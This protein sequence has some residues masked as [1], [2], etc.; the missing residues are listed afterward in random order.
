[1]PNNQLLGITKKSGDLSLVAEISMFDAADVAP[2]AEATPTIPPPP[3]PTTEEVQAPE[4][5]TSSSESAEAEVPASEPDSGDDSSAAT[6]EEVAADGEQE[7][8]PVIPTSTEPAATATDEAVESADSAEEDAT[9]NVEETVTEAEAV[10]ETE[11]EATEEVAEVLPVDNSESEQGGSDNTEEKTQTETDEIKNEDQTQS[12]ASEADTAAQEAIVEERPTLAHILTPSLVSQEIGHLVRPANPILI[13]DTT[14]IFNTGVY[15]RPTGGE[16]A[17]MF[18]TYSSVGLELIEEA[19]VETA[20]ASE[21]VSI[22]NFDALNDAASSDAPIAG[23][24]DA[25]LMEMLVAPVPLNA[26]P[27]TTSALP[28]LVD[29]QTI[30]A[31]EPNTEK[32]ELVVINDDGHR[33]IT[34]IVEGELEAGREVLIIKPNQDGIAVINDY[35]DESNKQYDAVIIYSHGINNQI[36][37]GDYTLTNENVADS[38]IDGFSEHLSAGADII[39]ASCNAA[40]SDSGKAMIDQIAELT[41]A[42]VGASSDSTGNSETGDWDLEYQTGAL[43]TDFAEEVKANYTGTDFDNVLQTWEWTDPQGLVHQYKFILHTGSDYQS[44]AAAETDAHAFTSAESSDWYLATFTSQAEYDAYLALINGTNEGP[45]DQTNWAGAWFGA[46]SVADGTNNYY[47]GDDQS[48]EYL[49]AIANNNQ[50]WDP[51]DS[52][53]AG[54]SPSGGGEAGGNDY[55]AVILNDVHNSGGSP[56]DSPEREGLWHTV[57]LDGSH[58]DSNPNPGVFQSDAYIIE[59]ILAAEPPVI[60]P[61]PTTPNNL[62]GCLAV[63]YEG[64]GAIAIAPNI[65]ITDPDSTNFTQLALSFTAGWESTD[66]VSWS[67]GAVPAG[68]S[69]SLATAADGTPTGLTVTGSA[70]VAAYNTLAQSITFDSTTQDATEVDRDI[71]WMVLDDTIAILGGPQASTVGTSSVCV[72][73]VPEP[74]VITPP[75]YEI[76]PVLSDP[77]DPN[78][79]LVGG[80]TAVYT[81]NGDPVLLAADINFTD[82]DS[83]NLTMAT[84][85]MTGAWEATDVVAWDAAVVPA[86]VTVTLATAADGTPTG[87]VIDGEATKD[88]YVAIAQSLNYMSTSE[89]PSEEPRELTW[90]IWDDTP[91]ETNAAHE[92]YLEEGPL[93]S[94]IVVTSVCVDAVP[95]PPVITPPTFELPP[96]LSDPND[97]DSPLVGGCTAVYTENGDPVL[98]AA[99]INFT[100]IDSENLTMATIDMTGAWEAT[101]VV[102]WDT[103]VVPAGVTVTLATAADGTPTGIVIDGEATKAEYVAIAQ[104]LNYMSTSENPS[105]EPRELTWEIWD[106]TPDQDNYAHE[107]ALEEGPLP[108]NI[109]VTSVCVDAV[110]DAPVITPPTYEI[111]PV[112]SDPDDPNSPL[113]GGCTAVYTENG[114]PVLLAADINFTDIDSDNLTMATIDMTGAWEATDVV[115]WDTA[116]VPAGVTVTL[117]TAADGTPTGIVIDGEATKA[118]YVAIAQSLNYMSTSEEPS[119][120]PRELTWEIWDDTPVEDNYAHENALEE[121][122]LPSN[123]VV[124]SV[125]VDAVPDAPVIVNE[126]PP[127]LNDPDDP[128]PT[129]PNNPDC[130][131]DVI[132][133]ENGEAVLL[134]PAIDFSD[135][136]SEFLTS[137]TIDFSSPL[138]EDFSVTGV[139][140]WEPT[141]IVTWDAAVVPAGVTVTLATAADGTPTGIVI[142]GEATLAEYEALFQSISYVTESERPSEG[143]RVITVQIWDDTPVEDNYAFENALEEGPLSSNIIVINLCVDAVPDAPDV[144]LNPN[145]LPC[146]EIVTGQGHVD[147]FPQ[148]TITDIDS[149]NLTAMNL[150]FTVNNGD[151]I[152]WDDALVPE[153][154][155]VHEAFDPDGVYYVYFTGTAPVEE[156]EALLQSFQ[157]QS[158]FVEGTQSHEIGVSVTVFDDTPVEENGCYEQFGENG[159]VTSAELG[160]LTDHDTFC[161][162]VY[163]PP[164]PPSPEHPASFT[165]IP[166]PEEELFLR[167]V[168]PEEIL[169]KTD[170]SILEG[171][172]PA[173][174]FIHALVNGQDAILNAQYDENHFV[175]QPLQRTLTDGQALSASLQNSID[176]LAASGVSPEGIAEGMRNVDPAIIGE[177]DQAMRLEHAIAI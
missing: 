28:L 109:V 78:S 67:A 154:V 20:S 101:D 9:A 96:V 61:D 116:V 44:W 133:V 117:A 134:M 64:D 111:P 10:V 93:P 104:S 98:L 115:A 165:M 160:A 142:D 169:R 73:A 100:D 45:I 172:T 174:I 145:N 171:D 71:T 88:E 110:P 25:D 74:P 138:T 3:E 127:E 59:T 144:E 36:I 99:D 141:D 129:Y 27:Q 11:A 56:A 35:L 143:E 168:E 159:G 167:H 70:S 158:N 123:I 53:P 43:E 87:I 1:M 79:P 51:N 63:W 135:L 91:D 155:S 26:I 148:A 31:L 37:L 72:D 50:N 107:N 22:V 4:E 29:E 118:E 17:D 121:G 108:S 47:W 156:Y 34:E 32:V 94:N 30:A 146:T 6:T 176:G 41:G 16:W 55:G 147:M 13:G 95:E 62:E 21:A 82:I 140:G 124:T 139:Q 42:D 126:Y 113:V 163:T 83:D 132:F 137:A 7:P 2:V 119:E 102:A 166:I 112:L 77:D 12:P 68:V 8:E 54:S 24:I 57:P 122:P 65:S 177:L 86:G 75:T 114:D 18:P 106:D 40:E 49:D 60:D 15:G 120:D 175:D 80:C 5:E 38:G 162:H 66:V 52:S 125:C 69:V 157:V 173:H 76:P 33:D 97:P 149:D 92:T 14:N 23:F 164:P 105:E 170:Y 84:I 128:F 19:Q 103:A 48:P 90:E 81:E 85:D 131:C 89:N 136:D 161:A 130:P 152:R 150:E 39:F 151:G 153:G 58:S 46:V